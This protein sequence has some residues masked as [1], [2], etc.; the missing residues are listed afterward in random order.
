MRTYETSN[1][2]HQIIYC[3]KPV[4]H[5]QENRMNLRVRKATYV[6]FH[7]SHL[8]NASPFQSSTSA[9]YA[10]FMRPLAPGYLRS[11]QVP[12]RNS[13]NDRVGTTASLKR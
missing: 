4:T 8:Q 2:E 10:L 1:I 13:H 5:S 3:T 6:L 12:Q 7:K 11:S 9:I